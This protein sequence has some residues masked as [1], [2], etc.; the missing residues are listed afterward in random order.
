MLGGK[1]WSMASI[2]RQNVDG[3]DLRPIG[4]RKYAYWPQG[5]VNAVL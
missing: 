3:A 2:I 4:M 1:P 5:V